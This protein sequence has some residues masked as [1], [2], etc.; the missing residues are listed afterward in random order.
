MTSKKKRE[1]WRDE[2]PFSSQAPVNVTAGHGAPS[3]RFWPA[4]WTLGISANR[5][6]IAAASKIFHG[7]KFRS[8]TRP[9]G[10]AFAEFRLPAWLA[11]EAGVPVEVLVLTACKEYVRERRRRDGNSDRAEDRPG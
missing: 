4:S 9:L 10:T 5:T 2:R 8:T 1:P 6:L 11:A 3:L 7:D